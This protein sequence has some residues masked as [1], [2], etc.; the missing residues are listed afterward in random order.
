MSTVLSRLLRLG[1][2]ALLL[3]VGLLAW[4][5]GA[6]AAED[7]EHGSAHAMHAD[8][9]VPCHQQGH[10][11]A[12]VPEHHKKADKGCC[13]FSGCAS[14]AAALPGMAGEAPVT[15]TVAPP[16]APAPTRLVTQ[17]QSGPPA[18]PPRL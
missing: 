11:D 18:E 5:G 7:M 2:P 15:F 1:L 4:N 17:A 14:A 3:A 16:L 6:Q 13:L 8:G 9:A 12:P 10:D